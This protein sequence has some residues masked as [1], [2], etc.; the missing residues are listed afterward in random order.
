MWLLF[1]I[2]VLVYSISVS[3]WN[4][5]GGE[6]QDLKVGAAAAVAAPDIV[7]NSRISTAVYLHKAASA[8]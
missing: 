3:A 4:E 5:G 8:I 1:Y 6:Q 2:T 7:L